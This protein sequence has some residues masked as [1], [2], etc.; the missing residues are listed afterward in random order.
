ML[1]DDAI[2]YLASLTYRPDAK[3]GICWIPLGGIQWD[4]ES[5]MSLNFGRLAEEDQRDI[6]KLFVIRYK[7]W[8]AEELTDSESL[9]WDSVRARVPDCPIVKRLN[10]SDE[11]RTAHQDAKV[12]CA[13]ELDEFLASADEVTF[14]EPKD[15]FQSFSAGFKLTDANT[16]AP[17]KLPWWRRILSKIH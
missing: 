5:T 8:D 11:D 2:T 12:S 17:S 1:S 15:G 14:G 9:L 3:C 6:Y 16:P 13:K 4:D 7:I 10:L